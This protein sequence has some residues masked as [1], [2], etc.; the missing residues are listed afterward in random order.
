VISHETI[1]RFIQAQIDRRKVSLRTMTMRMTWSRCSGLS[2]TVQARPPS[3]HRKSVA[4]SK[5]DRRPAS[6]WTLEQGA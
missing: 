2:T 3:C 1:Y 6:L 4:C 5:M